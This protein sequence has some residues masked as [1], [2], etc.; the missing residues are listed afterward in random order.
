MANGIVSNERVKEFGEVF[1]PDS[2]V[3]DMLD[4]VDKENPNE[5]ADSYINKTYLE[6]SCGDGQ[7][8]IRILYRKLERVKELPV[9]QRQL[10]LIKSLASIYGVDIQ[11]DNV[12]KSRKRMLQLATGKPVSTFDLNSKV[13]DIEIQLGIE[14]SEQLQNCINY[15]LEK[16]ILVGNTLDKAN[17]LLM[18]KWK[19][20]GDMLSTCECPLHGMELE[21]NPVAETFY[22]DIVNNNS[23]SDNDEE[24]FDF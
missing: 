5:D 21:L 15:V 2:I 1:T 19:F 20:N 4:L 13:Y 7:F 23:S 12:I 3:N 10:A 9:E 11:S 24:E 22:L 8:L 17:P 18:T 16:N 14:Y 6:P